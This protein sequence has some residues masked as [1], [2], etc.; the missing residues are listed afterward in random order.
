MSRIKEKSTIILEK[1]KSMV[2]NTKVLLYTGKENEPHL[3][4]DKY[5]KALP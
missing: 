3:I 5:R 2:I 4:K 1:A